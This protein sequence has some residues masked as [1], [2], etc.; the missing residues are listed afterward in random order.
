MPKSMREDVKMLN[1]LTSLHKILERLYSEN[2]KCE[3]GNLDLYRFISPGENKVI[4]I[5]ISRGNETD[6]IREVLADL[7]W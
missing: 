3:V 6:Y 2:W 1:R 7:E 4:L 5:D